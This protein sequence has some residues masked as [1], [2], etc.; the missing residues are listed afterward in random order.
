MEH[1]SF[2]TWWHH[3]YHKNIVS[4]HVK[5]FLQD[6]FEAG[7]KDHPKDHTCPNCGTVFTETV[8]SEREG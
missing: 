2:E 7:Q 8:L 3:Y 5:D 6:A 4:T 1:K